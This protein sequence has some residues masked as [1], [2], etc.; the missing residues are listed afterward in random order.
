[1]LKK[2]RDTKINIKLAVITSVIAVF[3]ASTAIAA[4]DPNVRTNLQTRLDIIQQQ[5]NA[6]QASINKTRQQAAS[7]N[8]EI[9][10]YDN[11]IASLELQIEANDTQ[12]Q[13]TTLQ[14]EELETQIA[15][16]KAEIDENK[17]IMA[18]LI[19]QIAQMDDNTFLNI[20]LGSDDFSSFLDQF[21]YARSVNDQVY[22]LVSKIKEIK[23]KLEIQQQ[24]LK[25]ELGKLEELKDQLEISQ[26]TLN[27]QKASKQALLAQ[28][29]G[30]EKNYQSLLGKS[31][32]EEDKLEQEMA[33]LEAAA[34]GRAG[35]VSISPKKG[36]LAWPMQ[37]T[38][39]QGYGNTGF[40]SL[41]YSFHNGIDLAAPAGQPI[42]SAADGVVAN[43][44]TGE[45]A[46]GNWCTIRHN[47]E[48]ASGQRDIIT[49]YAHMTTLKVRAGQAVKQGDLVGYEGNTGNTT[50]LIY[51][52]HRGFHLHFTVCDAKGY[53]VTK[54]Q[55]TAIY[56][57]YTVPSCV[58]YNP[59]NFLAK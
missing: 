22:S 2:L 21:Q 56:G 6:Y 54:G 39:T 26:K 55:H 46:Y 12:Q 51:G 43:C 42:Y 27:E 5:I 53:A 34:R 20:G 9:S 18:Q 23:S 11:Q 19:V 32:A 33:D 3:G 48:T 25:T 41:G 10:I 13:D 8:S 15:R 36:V 31:E 59:M 24:D 30:I 37:G 16:R 28:T 7:L 35:N 1:M 57:A 58:T 47:V 44:D 49:L 50:R 4:V 45:A 52:P 29:R 38:L 17:K 14:I 40:T